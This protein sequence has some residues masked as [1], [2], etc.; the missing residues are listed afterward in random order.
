MT[1][2]ATF[3]GL[4]LSL[5]AAGVAIVGVGTD[6]HWFGFTE[7]HGYALKEP[8]L[9]DKLTRIDFVRDAVLGS[10]DSLGFRP[11][12]LAIEEM[13]YG[14][15]GAAV[16]QLAALW[17]DVIRGVRD[18]G[19]PYILVNVSK[20]K[21]YATGQGNKV[22]KDEVMLAIAR[23]YRDVEIHDNNEADAFGLAAMA[24]RLSGRPLEEKLPD[25]H[26]RALKDLVLPA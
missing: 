8:T 13:P 23:R 19:I 4:D 5:T 24:A 7:N 22:G 14:A 21:I 25:T 20:L 18:R 3:A 10:L 17:M 2:L 12:L 11:D 16:H 6:D 26:T 15:S 9:E 1:R